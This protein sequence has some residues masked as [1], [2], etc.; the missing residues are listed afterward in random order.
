MYVNTWQRLRVHNKCL[1]IHLHFHSKVYMAGRTSDTI[2]VVCS[3]T[4]LL[5]EKDGC[6]HQNI[7]IKFP[8]AFPIVISSICGKSFPFS[9][10]YFVLF[11]L[12][13]F[14]FNVVSFQVF[15][16]YKYQN[17]LFTKCSSLYNLSRD[18]YTGEVELTSRALW[19]APSRTAHGCSSRSRAHTGQCRH[20]WSA[21]PTPAVRGTAPAAA[22]LSPDSRQ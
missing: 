21:A 7:L 15:I 17:I 5:I 16:L 18:L 14:P 11:L 1:H 20:H 3:P 2:F 22:R 12:R 9:F 8:C 10:P 6:D 19:R 13:Y 4:F